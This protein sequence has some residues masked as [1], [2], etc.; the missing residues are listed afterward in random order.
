MPREIQHRQKPDPF[1]PRAAKPFLSHL[2]IV[3]GYD[4]G[5]TVSQV[6]AATVAEWGVPLDTVIDHARANLRALPA[7]TWET[8]GES[9]WKLESQGG[10]N[11]S[12]LQLPKTFDQLPAKGTPLAMIPNRGVLLAT[13]TD[14]PIGLAALL[15][16]AR[17]S[18]QE[19]PWPLCGDL[20]RVSPT[21]I[22]NYAPDSPEAELL[23]TIKKIDIVSIYDAQKNALQAHHDAIKDD[24]YVATYGLLGTK[25]N[26]SELQSWCSWTQGVPSLLPTTDLVALVWDLNSTRKTTL[27]QRTD[28]ER[29]VGHYFKSTTEDPPRTRVDTFPNPEELIELQK[30]TV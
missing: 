7:P 13:G 5:Q 17:Q 28:V 11:E 6:K 9:V 22:T 21:G 25:D 24:V 4:H 27:L 19:A 3:I 14:E 23:A 12:L 16:A 30:L 26:P 20:F 8:A 2:E 1:P 18:I 15:G 29:L 10:Y